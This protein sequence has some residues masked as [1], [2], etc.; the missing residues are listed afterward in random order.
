MKS[1]ISPNVNRLCI[2]II[3][4]VLAMFKSLKLLK[5]S[6][7]AIGPLFVALITQGSSLGVQDV[8]GWHEHE[9]GCVLK[10]PA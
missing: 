2:L 4:A 9:A 3:R 8:Q 10:I 7:A 6:T 5:K 1:E